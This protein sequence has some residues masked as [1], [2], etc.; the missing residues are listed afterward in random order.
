MV[1]PFLDTALWISAT[2]LFLTKCLDVLSTWAAISHA[3][4]ETNP[5]AGSLMRKFGIR[6]G[7]WL[8][9]FAAFAIIIAVL[10]SIPSMPVEA[11]P[12]AIVGMLV[13]SWIQGAVAMTNFTGG[14][15]R[16]SRSVARFH[17]LG[18]R[19]LSRYCQRNRSDKP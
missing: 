1:P 10:L 2:I 16:I 4:Q 11:K 8:A 17:L 6:N 7:L 9:S 19:L 14:S 3:A 13:V 15:N 5:I 18:A 12:F